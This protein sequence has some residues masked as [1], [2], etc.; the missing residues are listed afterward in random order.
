M[1]IVTVL[2]PRGGLFAR[3]PR[4]QGPADDHGVE[5]HRHNANANYMCHTYVPGPFVDAV[6]D[7]SPP[8]LR[9]FFIVAVVRR[10]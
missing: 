2:V 1:G 9:E 6:R 10:P 4:Q 7:N 8:G 3:Q 5:R